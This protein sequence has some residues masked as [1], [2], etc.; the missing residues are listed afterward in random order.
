[1]RSPRCISLWYDRNINLCELSTV[2]LTNVTASGVGQKMVF[3]RYLGGEF[4]NIDLISIFLKI[5]WLA[6]H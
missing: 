6:K 4:Y 5:Y 1:M 3:S 2:L